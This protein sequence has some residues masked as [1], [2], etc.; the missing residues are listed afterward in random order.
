MT[1]SRTLAIAV[2]FASL[3]LGGAAIAA[4]QTEEGPQPGQTGV[5]Q[6]GTKVA[7]STTPGQPQQPM[8][9]ETGVPPRGTKV[10]PTTTPGHGGEQ[11]R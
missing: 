4:N 11:T 5:G 6:R 10:A 9:A 1:S 3:M 7:P 2:A 8:T